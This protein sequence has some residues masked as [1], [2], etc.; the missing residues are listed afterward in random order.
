MHPLIGLLRVRRGLR[1]LWRGGGGRVLCGL[2][3]RLGRGGGRGGGGVVGVGL[4]WWGVSLGLEWYGMWN[5]RF[6]IYRSRTLCRHILIPD[7]NR[8]PPKLI[9]GS[10]P[11]PFKTVV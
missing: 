10:N 11:G 7:L 9:L 6:T 2:G 3:R 1:L 4:R 5:L 8:I